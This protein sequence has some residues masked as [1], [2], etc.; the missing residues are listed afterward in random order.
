MSIYLHNIISVYSIFCVC[1]LFVCIADARLHTS[2]LFYSAF[3]LGFNISWHNCL[4]TPNDNYRRISQHC[5][6]FTRHW[7]RS[8]TTPPP[9]RLPSS[10]PVTGRLRCL[11]SFEILLFGC[12]SVCVCVLLTCQFVSVIAERRRGARNNALLVVVV[13]MHLRV[14]RPQG[15]FSPVKMRSTPINT[16]R[17]QS[18]RQTTVPRPPTSPSHDR[19]ATLAVRYQI[20]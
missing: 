13:M 17:Y 5:E 18:V 11:M 1:V 19:Q 14:K 10:S 8:S 6:Y 16:H 2:L 4:C 3:V 9:P 15:F 12:L 7:C 20:L